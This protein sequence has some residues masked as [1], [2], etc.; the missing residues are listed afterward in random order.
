MPVC[1]QSSSLGKC[2]LRSGLVPASLFIMPHHP[3]WL[4]A[5][6]TTTESQG[7]LLE[8]QVGTHRVVVIPVG[9][10]TLIVVVKVVDTPAGHIHLQVVGPL[11]TPEAVC[12]VLV[13]QEEGQLADMVLGRRITPKVAHMVLIIKAEDQT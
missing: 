4:L 8:D 2:T 10:T 12:L 11:R 6:V 9:A 7:D 3:R 5:L 13:D 1:L